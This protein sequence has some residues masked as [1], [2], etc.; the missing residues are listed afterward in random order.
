[1]VRTCNC[2][3]MDQ[4]KNAAGAG[5]QRVHPPTGMPPTQPVLTVKGKRAWCEMGRVGMHTSSTSIGLSQREDGRVAPRGV[6]V[7]EPA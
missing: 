4:R 3:R 2:G 1:M 7:V 6:G 5:G